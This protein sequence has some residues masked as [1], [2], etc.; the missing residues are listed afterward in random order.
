[1]GCFGRGSQNLKGIVKG[2]KLKPR[3]PH[4]GEEVFANDLH[5][6]LVAVWRHNGGVEVC[7]NLGHGTPPRGREQI[8]STGH[9]HGSVE[10]QAGNRRGVGSLA[11]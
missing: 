9:A 4:A 1:L 10:V 2:D 11:M 3:F 5:V 7:E 8:V 6:I